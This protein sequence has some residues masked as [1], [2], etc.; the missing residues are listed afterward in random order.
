MKVDT[1]IMAP[2]LAEIG[3][4]A[5]E[6]EEIGYDGL[7]TAETAHDPFLPLAIAAEHTERDRARRPASRSRSPARRC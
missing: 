1:G 5:A 6:L 2:S 7:M 3:R 4:R